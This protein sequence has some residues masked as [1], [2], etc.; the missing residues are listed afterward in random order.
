MILGKDILIPENVEICNIS[1][2]YHS[3]RELYNFRKMYN[4][5]L[6]NEWAKQKK[7]SVHKSLKHFEGDYCFDGKYFI[8]VALL[9]TGQISNHYKLKDWDLFKIPVFSKAMI[10]YDGHTAKD[11]LTRLESFISAKSHAE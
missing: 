10:P 11:V 3:F 4:A 7:Y 6:F 8:V 5:V 1:D 9:P 2:G